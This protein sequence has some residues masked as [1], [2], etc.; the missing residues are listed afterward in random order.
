MFSI[1]IISI[2]GQIVEKVPSVIREQTKPQESSVPNDDDKEN[3]YDG[4]EK[5][6]REQGNRK[7]KDEQKKKTYNTERYSNS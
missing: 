1:T 3:T 4:I 6:R 2:A 5:K 7:L